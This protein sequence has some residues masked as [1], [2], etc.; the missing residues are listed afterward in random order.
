MNQ[1]IIR[2]K[3]ALQAVHCQLATA[4]N[5][6]GSKFCIDE[7][8]D[9]VPKFLPGDTVMFKDRVCHVLSVV[10]LPIGE[11]YKVQDVQGGECS[12]CFDEDLIDATKP[13]AETCDE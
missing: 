6:L 9:H 12:F 8:T 5:E 10:E 2:L 13:Y 11:S 3:K 1:D 7:N 4:R